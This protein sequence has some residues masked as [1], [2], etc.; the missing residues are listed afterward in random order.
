[1][2]AGCYARKS[3]DQ[4]LPSAEKSVTRQIEHA[5]AY[6]AKKGWT[7]D[8]AHVYS[9]DGISGAEFVERPGF[10][11][12]MNALKPKPPFQVLIMSEESRLG[13]EQIETAWS[14]KQIMDAGVRVFFYLED[15][16]RTLDTAMDKVM[17]SLTGFA[18]EMERE[19]A[20]QRTHDALRRKVLAGH[21]AGGAVYGYQNVEVRSAT[22]QRAHV[23]R[24]IDPSQADV[25]RRIFA[26]CAA[27][28]GLVRTAKLLNAEGMPG[29]HGRGWA[30]T[31]IREMLHRDLY[32][33]VVV[34]NKTKWV[35][36][37]GTKRKVDRPESEWLTVEVP[38]CRIVD[39]P[40]WTAAQ[41]RLTQTRAAYLR[42]TGGK[43]WGRP[44]HGHESRYLLTGFSMCGVCGGSF[45]VRTR[46]GGGLD[47]RCA[48]HATRGP[49]ICANGVALPVAR[50][51]AEIIGRLQRDVLTPRV[52]EAAITTALARYT[53]E[54]AGA[55]VH[56]SQRRT[57][58]DRLERE[59]ARL[60]GLL[61]TG[62]A[63]RVS[64]RR[65]G[66]ARPSGPPSRRSWPICG[67]WPMPPGPG[68]RAG[69][70]RRSGGGSVTG[71]DCLRASPRRPAR[72][73]GSSWSGAWCGRPNGMRRASGT[74]IPP[75]SL[76]PGSWPGSSVSTEW[77]PRRGLKPSTDSS[78]GW[79]RR[80]K[81]PLRARRRVA[82]V[83]RR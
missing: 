73:S 16:E 35:D 71:R 65:C 62:A 26:L 55:T 46:T 67:G 11:R 18:A 51:N 27:G 22:G 41:A 8:P 4:N 58:L 20:K 49:A 5:T 68:T 15:R 83:A 38:D 44:E 75:R 47:Y 69:S 33:G 50:A 36:K 59:C 45:S 29:P 1:M 13:R 3:T 39:E 78:G 42:W 19:K 34:W 23:R 76:T 24:V 79:C 21:V 6:A 56:A 25:V 32:R 43:L 7:V 82:P 2:L 72:C 66:P 9:D 30:P 14:L 12:L 77:C 37:G 53:A 40:L 64:W 61:A 17:L 80:R 52:V 63:S 60:A 57:E 81:L 31:A 70:A 54:T 74:P 48:F 28:K 10:L